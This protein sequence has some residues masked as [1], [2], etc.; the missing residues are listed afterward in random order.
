MD[1][2]RLRWRLVVPGGDSDGRATGR[3][4]VSR[5]LRGRFLRVPDATPSDIGPYGGSGTPD[6]RGLARE[7]GVSGS[8]SDGGASGSSAGGTSS[9]CWRAGL[10]AEGRHQPRPDETW[11]IMISPPTAEGR[12]E[13]LA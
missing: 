4:A 7:G 1:G 10:R 5:G 13:G 9:G 11:R 3:A 6:C 2:R 8:R 12:A